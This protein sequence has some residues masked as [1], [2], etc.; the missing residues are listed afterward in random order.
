MEGEDYGDVVLLRDV[1]QGLEDGLKSLGIVGIVVAMDGGENIGI[2]S[3]VEVLND[4]GMFA[5]YGGKID[6]V[7]IHHIATVADTTV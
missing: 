2:G 5:S 6:T 1:G 4:R 3:K 7:V